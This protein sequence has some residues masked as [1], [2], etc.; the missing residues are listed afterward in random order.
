MNKLTES[1]I[2]LLELIH[3][4]L[5]FVSLP[6]L[7]RHVTVWSELGQLDSLELRIRI[8]LSAVFSEWKSPG[9]LHDT[10]SSAIQQPGSGFFVFADRNVV[11]GLCRHEGLRSK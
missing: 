6:T 8:G 3:F 10:N 4:S 5:R 7:S 1:L 11:A 2:I 9:S